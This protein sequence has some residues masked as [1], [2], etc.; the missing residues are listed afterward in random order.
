MDGKAKKVVYWALL[1]LAVATFVVGW[2]IDQTSLAGFVGI[3]LIL[4]ATFGFGPR[5]GRSGGLWHKG[6][7]NG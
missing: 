2:L 5:R 4:I 6:D 3:A 1:A 7:G